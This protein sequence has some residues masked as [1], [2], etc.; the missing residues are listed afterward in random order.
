MLISLIKK[1]I[2]SGFILYGYNIIAVNFN[3]T[4]PINFYTLSFVTCL[5]SPALIALIL[6]KIVVL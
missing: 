3:V 1:I 2:V 4:I 6:F 5:G